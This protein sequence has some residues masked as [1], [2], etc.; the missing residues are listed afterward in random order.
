MRTTIIQNL[1]RQLMEVENGDL[2]L[3]ENFEKKLQHVTESNAFVRPIAGLHSV[4]EILSHLIIW[5]RINIRR[6]NGEKVDI[7]VTHPDNW[8]TNEELRHLGWEP[9]LKDFYASQQDVI[10]LLDG[11]DDKYLETVSTHHGKDFKY[12]VEGLVHHDFYH[13]G[14]LG[15]TI[16][17]LN[18][19][20]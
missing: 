14:Q 6:M 18:I 17:Y 1:I 9:I 10:S 15:L 2:W 5:R 12:L 4:A 13:L 3:D 19:P 16:K 7:P 8:K 11:K 20:N